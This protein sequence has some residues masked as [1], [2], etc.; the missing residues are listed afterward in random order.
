M[1]YG[2]ASFLPFV[3]FCVV[4][5]SAGVVMIPFPDTIL[6]SKKDCRSIW[7]PRDYFFSA[8]QIVVL[9]FLQENSLRKALIPF[10]GVRHVLL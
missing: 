9:F 4:T 6:L 8:L 7:S 3:A 2:V 1:A 5:L 10:V